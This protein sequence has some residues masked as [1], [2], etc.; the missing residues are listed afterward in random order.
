MT[1]MAGTSREK[2]ILRV[3]QHNFFGTDMK[4][5]EDNGESWKVKLQTGGFESEPHDVL[6]YYSSPVLPKRTAP[7]PQPNFRNASTENTYVVFLD[8]RVI[9]L[10][11][12][13]AQHLDLS[14]G[15][16]EVYHKR[17]WAAVTPRRQRNNWAPRTRDSQPS[18]TPNIEQPMKHDSERCGNSAI[19]HWLP[20]LGHSRLQSPIFL[21]AA[22]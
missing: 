5:S 8:V 20:S 13:T 21:A 10:R 22:P 1:T 3:I 19:G 6:L 2:D 12:P 15:Q 9:D 4:I 16:A 18:Q 14:V 7:C 11:N 17:K